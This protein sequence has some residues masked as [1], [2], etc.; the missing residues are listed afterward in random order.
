MVP[1]VVLQKHGFP[2]PTWSWSALISWRTASFCRFN[3]EIKVNDFIKC[4]YISITLFWINSERNNLQGVFVGLL[5][6]KSSARLKH[7]TTHTWGLIHMDFTWTL[8]LCKKKTVHGPKGANSLLASFCT[9]YTVLCIYYSTQSHITRCNNRDPFIQ[10]VILWWW[11]HKVWIIETQSLE[12][13]WNCQDPV[14]NPGLRSEKQ[15]LN[16]LSHE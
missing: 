16:Q 9:L 2:K 1:A 6:L 11:H 13:V 15:S 12:R 14:T 7:T 5:C 10:Y 3:C 8:C 4:I